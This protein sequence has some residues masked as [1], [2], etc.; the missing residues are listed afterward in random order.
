M[1]RTMYYKTKWDVNHPPFICTLA[2]KMHRPGVEVWV[3]TPAGSKQIP[4]REVDVMMYEKREGTFETLAE[5]IATRLVKQIE[6]QNIKGQV[7]IRVK[8]GEDPDF[9][10]EAVEE[11]EMKEQG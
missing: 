10:V 3:E 7:K 6:E 11:K 5:R 1:K 8:V 2:S 9:W 4:Y